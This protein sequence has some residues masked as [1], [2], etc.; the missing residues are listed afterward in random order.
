MKCLKF[1]TTY[2]DYCIVFANE[3]IGKCIIE[4]NTFIVLT[5]YIVCYA[6][7]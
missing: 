7:S 1:D 2:F 4:N 3:L 6:V 5:F